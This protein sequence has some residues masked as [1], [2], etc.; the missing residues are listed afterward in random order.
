MLC[1]QSIGS[2]CC[3]CNRNVGND[4]IVSNVPSDVSVVSN[5]NIVDSSIV[6]SVSSIS[7]VSIAH[8]VCNSKKCKQQQ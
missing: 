7:N 8:A 1:T 5:V 2:V 3:V 6:R 4:C